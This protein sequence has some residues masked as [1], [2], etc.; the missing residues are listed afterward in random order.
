[1]LLINSHLKKFQL[2]MK[3]LDIKLF[4]ELKDVS[5]RIGNDINL[6]QVN[7]GNTSI[8]INE[9][10][11]IKAS[12][13]HLA[14]AKKENI[15]TKI[16]LK[17]SVKK[18]K[19][20]EIKTNNEMLRPSI[21][22]DMHKLISSKI[23]L[24]TH[25]VDLISLTMT[26]EGKNIIKEKLKDFKW[27]WI[28]Y[29]KPGSELA[30]EI[31]KVIDNETNI[32]ILQNHGLVV[33]AETATDAE[34]LQR[35][36]LKKL[37]CKRREYKSLNKK[38]LK[39]FIDNLKFEAFLPENEIIHTLATDPLSFKLVQKN[40]YSPDH[41]VFF[42]LSVPIID[43]ME[44]YSSKILKK[45]DFIIIKDLGVLILKKNK[46]L[47]VMLRTQAEVFLRISNF[48]NVNLLSHSQCEELINW[49]AEKLRRKNM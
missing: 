10:V 7:G 27:V 24:H 21:E 34:K 26:R 6:V 45:N 23:V 8:K 18:N 43:N 42:G 49:E 44:D 16:P 38:V 33:G 35:D 36:V 11:F 37:K 20:I 15:F 5:A 48:K 47:E 31:K 28:N 29:S 30:Q 13:K 32:L 2:I 41:A 22:K 40:P 25:P 4:D 39:S 46:S 12:G 14:N 17:D 19:L 9:H 1:M 3:E